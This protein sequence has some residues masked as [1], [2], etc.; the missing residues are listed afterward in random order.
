[1][2]AVAQKF[3]RISPPTIYTYIIAQSNTLNTH[4]KTVYYL[5]H[6][7][8]MT[9][10]KYYQTRAGAR[11]A[12][13]QRNHRLG[14]VTRLDRIDNDPF[15]YELCV[16]TDGRELTGTYSILEDTIDT[17]DIIDHGTRAD[18]EGSNTS[19]S[20]NQHAGG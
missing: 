20:N 17:V 12:M 19:N 16:T 10:L 7:E 11:I 2:C 6:W 14:F 1:M 9:R 3:P 8:S 13:R 18:V 5:V 15:E 4:M